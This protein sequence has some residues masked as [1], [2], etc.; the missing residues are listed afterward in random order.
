M[1][2]RGRTKEQIRAVREKQRQVLELSL[3][4]LSFSQIAAQLGYAGESSARYA[5]ERALA[6]IS[7]VERDQI[8]KVHGE[9]CQRM[10]AKVWGELAGHEVPDPNNPNKKIVVYN[11]PL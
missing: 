2:Q 5:W 9:R 11:Y 8:R 4:G 6:T 7:E 1:P 3:R 10:R